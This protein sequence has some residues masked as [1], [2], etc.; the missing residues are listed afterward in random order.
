LTENN[1]SRVI[2]IIPARKGSKGLPKKNQR[3]VGFFTLVNRAIKVAKKIEFSKL[4][5]L[6]SDD[7]KIIRKYGNKVDL[8]IVRKPELSTSS[9]SIV[10]VIKDALNKVQNLS[11]DD[12]VM[13]LEPSS[14]N[15]NSSDLNS[16]IKAMI[17]N[18]YSSLITV[19]IVDLKYHPY[20]ILKSNDAS[21][22]S[23]YVFHSPKISNRQ[24]I[25]EDAYYRNGILYMYKVKVAMDMSESLPINTHFVVTSRNVSNVDNSLDLWKARWFSLKYYILKLLSFD[26]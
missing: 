18:G 21:T 17:I 26:N 23:S 19:S 9:A 15:R 6:S 1:F 3:F 7:E 4:I 12:L 11:E 8:C 13:L 10:D 25:K 16:A 5:I 2:C 22:L 14:P 20:K 24:E